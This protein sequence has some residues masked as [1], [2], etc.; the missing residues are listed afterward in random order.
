MTQKEITEILLK[1]GIEESQA[2]RASKAVYSYW[3][4]GT[5]ERLTKFVACFNE[6]RNTRFKPA[7]NLMKNFDY[8]L[9]VYTPEE[10]IQAIKRCDEGFW[11]DKDLSP[12]KLLRTRNTN[13]DCDYISDLLNYKPKPVNL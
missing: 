4:G 11:M 9:K 5:M 13:G 7:P 1:Q 12:T 8:W 6:I 2:K 10:M 3:K